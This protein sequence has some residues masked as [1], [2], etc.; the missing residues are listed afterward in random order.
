[1]N[2]IRVSGSSFYYDSCTSC[3]WAGSSKCMELRKMMKDLM[4]KLRGFGFI[5]EEIRG[6]EDF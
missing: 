1:M 5:V 6:T 4:H 3:E 2:Q